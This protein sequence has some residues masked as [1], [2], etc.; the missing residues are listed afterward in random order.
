MFTG[1]HYGSSFFV[2]F[3]FFFLNWFSSPCLQDIT[4]TVAMVPRNPRPREFLLSVHDIKTISTIFSTTL[5]LMF[6]VF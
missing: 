3:Y 1:L 2:S 5:G 6:G 4:L